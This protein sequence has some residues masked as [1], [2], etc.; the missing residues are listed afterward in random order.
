[1]RSERGMS[2]VNNQITYDVLVL[3]GGSMGTAASYYLSKQKQRVLMIDQFTI[4]NVNGS[5]HGH[6]RMLRLG[7]GNGGKYVP[8]AVE[9]LKLWKD[10]EEE[11]GKVLYKKTGAL[12]VGH[13]SSRF[14]KEAIESCIQYELAYEKMNA[15]MIMERWPGIQI[16]DT[17]FG[18]F[19]PESGFLFSEKCLTTYKEQAI[20]QGADV[21]ENLA[22][23]DIHINDEKVEVQTTNGV[24]YS[25]KLVITAGAWIPKL[26]S[27]MDLP[28]QPVR[29]TI[30]WFQPTAE[31]L[32]SNDF[33]CFIFDTESLGHYYGFPDFDGSG[34]KLGRMDE[35]YDCDPVT[36]NREFGAYVDDEGDIRTFLENFL[37]YAAG[38]LLDGKTCMFA[39]T[40]D[41]N[42]IV[43]IHPEH[44]NVVLAGGFSGHGFKFAS[45]IGSILSDLIIHGKTAHD[46]SF[47]QLIRFAKAQEVR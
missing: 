5:H 3:G 15:Q 25:N 13:P 26:L 31:Q 28:I 7:Y 38:D 32:Y 30:G 27:S 11:T 43:D 24:Y 21:L 12:T 20:A 44:Q 23:I 16:P 17:Y 39:N 22:V 2:R 8:L 35:G 37:P 46:I 18:C 36:V 45:V 14:V 41:S 9:S 6:T 29:K 4:P 42:F 40:P 10:L 47:L 1:M 33:P 34:V 19:D